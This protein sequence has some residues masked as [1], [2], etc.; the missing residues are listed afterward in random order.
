MSTI[1]ELTF[2]VVRNL[3]GRYFRRK[4]YGGGGDTWVADIERARVYAKI[5]SARA[6][7]SFFVSKYPQFGT[8]EILVMKAQLFEVLNETERVQKAIESKKLAKE[9]QELAEVN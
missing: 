3:E 6:V 2:Y 1:P 8:P 5:G 4:G 7:V 9:K